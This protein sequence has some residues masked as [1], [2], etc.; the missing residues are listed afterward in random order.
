MTADSQPA[1][2]DCPE[3]HGTGHKVLMGVFL[4]RVDEVMVPCPACAARAAADQRREPAE[5]AKR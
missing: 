3:C 5:P 4:D 2:P 1:Y